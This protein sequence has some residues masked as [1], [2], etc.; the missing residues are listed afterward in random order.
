[1]KRYDCLKVLNE[2]VT[3]EDLVITSLGGLIEEWHSIRPSDGNMSFHILGT[4]TPLA[5]GLA[6]ALPHRRVICIDT[7][8]SLFLNLGVLCTL[9]NQ[10]PKNLIVY[11]LDNK[12]Y[13]CI[14]GP[15]TP[16]AGNVDIAKMAIGAGIERAI[17]VHDLEEFDRVT[18]DAFNTKALSFIVCKVE[19]GTKVFPKEK[20]KRT[21]GI[22]DKY[23]F[24]RYIEKLEGKMIKPCSEHI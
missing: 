7:D 10:R 16:S 5:L 13:E 24:L 17:D 19:P 12:C 23:K 11:I 6:L 1:M 4:H 14:G 8:G 2:Y 9:G 20:W 22:E 3:E 18:K 21:D 15:R